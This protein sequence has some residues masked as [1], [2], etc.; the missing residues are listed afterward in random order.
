MPFD[1][2]IHLGGHRYRGHHPKE[3]PKKKDDHCC[4]EIPQKDCC[5]ITGPTGPTGPTGAT[6]SIGPTGATGSTGA[7]GATGESGAIGPTGP[8]GPTGESGP[9]GPT[10]ATG[11]IGPTGPTGPTG[12]DG[13]IGPTGPTGDVGPTGPTGSTGPT[14]PTGDI[15]PTGPT[16]PTGATGEVVLAYGSLRGSSVETPGEDFEPVPFNIVGP[17]SDTITVSGTGNELVVGESGIYQITVSINA[18]ATTDPD[19]DQPFLDAIITVNGTPIFGDTTTFF[20]IANRSSS[21]FV[22]QAALNAGDEV[23][24]SIRTDFPDI[25]GYMNRSLTI[26]QLS[27]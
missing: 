8:T 6:G 2:N 18:E 21:T 12:E 1:K 20:K 17:L 3:L 7:T 4:S 19:P 5:V 24:V 13:P 27:D 16:G 22:V 14:G 11:D 26:V 9:T 23:G 25:L 15:G 10:G